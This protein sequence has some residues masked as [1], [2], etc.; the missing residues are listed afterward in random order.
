MVGVKSGFAPVEVDLQ[1]NKGEVV[2][3][4]VTLRNQKKLFIGAFYCKPDA[5]ITHYTS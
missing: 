1:D 5:E 2:W 4:Q 3:A